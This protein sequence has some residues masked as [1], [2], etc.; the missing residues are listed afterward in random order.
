MTDRHSSGTA[1][2]SLLRAAADPA[3]TSLCL[4]TIAL[5]ESGAFT[6]WKSRRAH[7]FR[8]ILPRRTSTISLTAFRCVP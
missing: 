7:S 6:W 4:R 8:K 2:S 5:H 1:W 3:K